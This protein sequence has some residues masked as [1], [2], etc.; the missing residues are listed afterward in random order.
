M[1]I[2]IKWNLYFVKSSTLKIAERPYIWKSYFHPSNV[3][4]LS[5]SIMLKLF[6]RKRKNPK[7]K[8]VMSVCK[9]TLERT[10]RVGVEPRPILPCPQQAN[11]EHKV[12]NFVSNSVLYYQKC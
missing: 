4:E 6:I 1:S 9:I 2:Q 10:L 12:S 5:K 7:V 3:P 8:T 11:I